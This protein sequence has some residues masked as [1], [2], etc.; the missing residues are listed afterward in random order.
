MG[1][2][3]ILTITEE[4]GS[5]KGRGQRSKR[6]NATPRKTRQFSVTLLGWVGADRWWQSG[7]TERSTR[8]VWMAY[9]GSESAVRAFTA[10]LRK[11]RKAALARYHSVDDSFEIPKSSGHRFLVERHGDVATCSIYLPELFHLE[12]D[13]HPHDGALRF[14]FM[15]PLWWLEA[16]TEALRPEL[17]ADAHDAAMAALF[18]AYLDRRTPLPMVRD[19]RFHLQLYRA[20]LEQ[21]WVWEALDPDRRRRMRSRSDTYALNPS[22]CGLTRPLAVSVDEETFQDFL[23]Q[24]T[25]DFYAEEIAH[26]TSRVPGLGRL[27][28]YPDLSGEQLRLHFEA[29]GG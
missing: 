10:N 25:L 5:G 13:L 15:P 18:V 6:A 24:Q 16:Q 14:L 11:G 1:D 23:T 26:G 17:G 27:L 20:A 22:L 7:S 21:P 2:F 29:A 4:E 8:P 3:S 9:A 19:L 12:P 28:P